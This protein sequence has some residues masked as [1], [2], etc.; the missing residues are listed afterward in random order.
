VSS[1]IQNPVC[2][3][4]ILVHKII[5]NFTAHCIACIGSGAGSSCAEESTRDEDDSRPEFYEN[6]S[7]DFMHPETGSY[8][9]NFFLLS[10]FSH[11][12]C[13]NGSCIY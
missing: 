10:S 7:D 3:G 9:G 2:Q 11:G 5:C 12:Q 6:T 4:R 8:L 1:A 13:C